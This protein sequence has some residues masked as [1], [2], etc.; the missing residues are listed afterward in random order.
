MMLLVVEKYFQQ[1]E[2][3]ASTKVPVASDLNVISVK[4]L[5]VLHKI[6]FQNRERLSG[7]INTQFNS[8]FMKL[9]DKVGT[10]QSKVSFSFLGANER[11]ILYFIFILFFSLM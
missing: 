4:D 11:R 10:Y 7:L 8:E 3:P 2:V 1:L 6:V 9:L 5:H